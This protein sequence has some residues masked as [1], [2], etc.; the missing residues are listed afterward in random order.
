MGS[1]N[2]FLQS[3]YFLE[4]DYSRW[5]RNI[6]P[7]VK[8]MGS[9]GNRGNGGPCVF[10]EENKLLGGKRSI[11]F[12]CPYIPFNGTEAFAAALRAAKGNQ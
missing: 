5:H 8:I 10:C 6:R 4:S 11:S 2:Y 7:T 12:A 9:I 3:N 1:H